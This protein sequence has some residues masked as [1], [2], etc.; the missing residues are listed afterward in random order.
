M[1]GQQHRIIICMG[2]SCFSRG[3]KKSVRIIQDYLREHELGDQVVLS[4]SH[5]FGCCDQGPI[6][7]LN[8]KVHYQVNPDELVSIL[9][10]FFEQDQ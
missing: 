5:C 8:D 4:G 3:N 10:Q 7:Q 9:D 1:S 6:V 2:S